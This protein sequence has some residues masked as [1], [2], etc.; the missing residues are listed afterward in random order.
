[1]NGYSGERLTFCDIF[2]RKGYSVEIPIIQRDYAQGRES[3]VQVRD[4]FL[5]S[6]YDC[7]ENDKPIDLDFIYGSIIDQKFIPLDGQQRLTTLFLLHWYVA[8]KEV[9]AESFRE[10]ISDDDKT[11]FSYETRITSRDF[12]N[13]LVTNDV[14]IPSS[15][16][17]SVSDIIK[18]ASWFF[19]SWEKDPT[20]KSMLIML[21]AMHKKFVNSYNLF[22]KLTNGDKPLI[23]FQFIELENFGLSDSLYIRMNARG[24]ELTTFEAFKAKFEQRLEEY[25]QI[26]GSKLK[27][28]FAFKIDTAWTDLFWAYK[29]E[30]TKLFDDKF[31]H[32]IRVLATNE[33]ALSPDHSSENL[34]TLVSRS[35]LNF[36]DFKRLD[37]LDDNF[38]ESFIR[39]LDVFA[40]RGRGG[41]KRHLPDTQLLDESE[42]FRK[43]IGEIRISYSDRV[44]LWALY[45]YLTNYPDDQQLSEWIRVIRNLTENHRID[46]IE[47]YEAALKSVAELLNHG[48]KILPYI[49]DSSHQISGFFTTQVLE[50]RVKALLIM[51]GE[52]WRRAITNIENHGYFKGQIGFILKFSGIFEFFSR[53]QTLDWSAEDNEAYLKK[54]LVYSEKAET[55]FGPSGLKEEYDDF[56]FERALLS[57]GNYTLAKGPNRSFLI[58]LD[59]D[60]GWKRLLRDDSVQ[61]SYVKEL[62]DNVEASQIETDLQRIVD[63]S[64]VNDW[65]RY[66]IEFPEMIQKCGYYKFIRWGSPD[67]IL[68]LERTQTN[69]KH[70]EYYT[71]AL[72]IRLR[73]MGNDAVYNPS[74]SVDIKACISEINGHA[75]KIEYYIYGEYVV[76]Y[77]NSSNNFSSQDKVIEYL[78]KNK[79]LRDV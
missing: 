65:R 71:Y 45:K 78:K 17:N 70:R 59:R 51:K 26:H 41:I 18:D 50:E 63:K 55:V 1:M 46:E 58:D 9:K 3:A 39:I 62:F 72:S 69:G 4:N 53:D 64:K 20:I 5:S 77:G 48:N 36:D 15:P 44:Q 6:L 34:G 35:P 76:A 25:D 75:I 27:G 57:I 54:F 68:L 12:C 66:F 11:R 42:L 43:A 21:D 13:A 74:R 37:C 38:I 23:T 31:M 22:E 47:H 49:A 10:M 28:D 52:E 30:E 33:Y 32:F 8:S 73:E 29:N 67:N 7:L 24:I 40:E 2:R 16:D 19:I 14:L 61:R 60:I 79:L 56:L